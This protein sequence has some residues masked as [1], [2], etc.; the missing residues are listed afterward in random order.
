MMELEGYS[1]CLVAV[2][3]GSADAMTTDNSILAGYAARKE[4]AGKFKLIGL[5]LSNENY[6]IGVKKGN[7]E[8]QKKINA[9]LTK[10][11][12]DGSWKRP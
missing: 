3:D 8:L 10:M 11:V 4:N 7:K 6:G 5:S 9:A 1:E 12:T 2:Q